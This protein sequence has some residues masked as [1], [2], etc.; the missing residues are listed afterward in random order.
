MTIK[1]F[2]SYYISMLN[3]ALINLNNL[4]YNA[5]QI[6]SKLNYGVK[7][8][9]VVKADAYGHGAVKCSNALY[10]IV[11]CFAV[12][13]VEEGL[14]LRYGGIDKEILVLISAKNCDLESAILHGLTLTVQSKNDLMHVYRESKR[15]NVKAKIHIKYDT[16]MNRQGIKDL[17]EL[18]EVIK[19]IRKR[20]NYVELTGFYSHFYNPSDKRALKKCEDKF[21]LAKRLIKSYNK[22]IV[23]HISAS[24][25]F[26]QDKQFDMV[27]I[28]IMLYGYKPFKSSKV[29]LKRVMK[30]LAPIISSKSLTKGENL[31]YG[32]YVL[33][34][35]TTATLVRFGYADGL[36]RANV[37]CKGQLNN[38]CMDVTAVSSEN[39]KTYKGYFVV[40]DDA[41]ILAKKYGTISYEILTKIS[42]RAQKIYLN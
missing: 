32:D 1:G 11:D 27:R 6:K 13:L 31:L 18:A 37:S 10:S 29:K 35:N 24:G 15:L 4:V 2:F 3:Q 7:F 16:G 40:M 25:G 14:A 28:G 34:K 19:Y 21:L 22:N 36:P 33:T 38:R 17:T 12:A 30:V 5:K 23:C 20:E 8:C 9:A 39:I 41:D 26:L 42:I